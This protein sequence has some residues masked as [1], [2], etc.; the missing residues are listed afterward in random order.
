MTWVRDRLLRELPTS[1][2]TD[3]HAEPGLSLAYDG[4]ATV[5]VFR[6]R[7]TTRVQGGTGTSIAI[8]LTGK[9]LTQLVTELNSYAGY[10][11][12]V[13]ADDGTRPAI[14]LIE[15]MDKPLPGVSAST[16]GAGELPAGEAP[17]GESGDVT[18]AFSVTADS[19]LDQFTSLLWNIVV[20]ISWILHDGIDLQEHAAQQSRSLWSAEG[21]W[22]EYWGSL[23][24]GTVRKSGETDAPFA[25]RIMREVLRPRLNNVALEQILEDELGIHALV[26]NLFP[27]AWIV[28]GTLGRIAGRKYSR[29]TFEVTVSDL[30]D[31]VK[32]LVTRSRAAGTLP[33]YRYQILQGDVEESDF[34]IVAHV[35]VLD[36]VS[37]KYAWVLG[38]DTC[39]EL[40]IFGIGG[41]VLEHVDFAPVT[42]A[43]FRIG[44]S[45]DPLI[46]GIEALGASVLGDVSMSG[47]ILSD[48]A[49][50]FETV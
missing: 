38:R 39:G 36:D 43:Y 32:E 8:D 22:L 30:I 3:P 12:V 45:G 28:G 24:G 29:T 42:E 23:Y 44:G 26:T 7:L 34:S 47:V 2:D 33:F 18:V 20:P 25:V 37:D 49:G 17:A 19:R 48:T 35:N 13:T 41:T 14:G 11:A 27:E 46:L 6:R 10:T 5:T 16:G 15:V 4:V 50:V 1:F 40:P 21:V 31:G 9:S